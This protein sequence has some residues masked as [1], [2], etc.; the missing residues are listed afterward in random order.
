MSQ[1]EWLDA[2]PVDAAPVMDAGDLGDGARPTEQ[3]KGTAG[4][5]ATPQEGGPGDDRS[6]DADRSDSA[7]DGGPEVPD[8]DALVDP[9]ED[10][11]DDTSEPDPDP[12]TNG[13]FECA[14]LEV[15]VRA[16]FYQPVTGAIV[17]AQV[18]DHS[19]EGRTE[20]GYAELMVP[21][22]RWLLLHAQRSGLWNSVA[23]V[24][25]SAGASD[26][27]G[28]MEMFSGAMLQSAFSNVGF[29][30]DPGKGLLFA[31]FSPKFVG[32]GLEI[33][34]TSAP[35]FTGPEWGVVDFSNRLLENSGPFM[36]FANI[37]PG[38]L[39]LTPLSPDGVACTVA[40]RGALA[41]SAAAK[42]VLRVTVLC[43]PS[44]P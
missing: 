22:G 42:T 21:S 15:Y 35:A 33:G 39:T 41:Y 13:T 18:G 44:T 11:G 9:T 28:F 27:S 19:F 8:D 34:R 25:I 5:Q 4:A 3:D 14:R 23:P 12:C 30:Q 7:P 6:M 2:A 16:D 10:A 43:A 1:C 24:E 40:D 32:A 26:G 17:S 38:P 31:G 20:Q 36:N 37:D 29:Q